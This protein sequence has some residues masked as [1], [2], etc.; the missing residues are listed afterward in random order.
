MLAAGE[1]RD[2]SFTLR[3]GGVIVSGTV[4]DIGGGPIANATVHLFGDNNAAFTAL[5]AA[6]GAYRLSIAPGNFSVQVRH[7]AYAG[8][9]RNVAVTGS[10][11]LDWQLVPAGTI[12]GVVIAR[13]T[14]RPVPHASVTTGAPFAEAVLAGDD[15]TFTLTGCPPGTVRLSANAPG[16]VADSALALPVGVGEHVD[17]VTLYADRAFAI[18][19]RV[20]D[21]K[22]AAV[23][24]AV[25]A[26]DGGA[27]V[28]TGADGAFELDR[29]PRSPPYAL[30]ATSPD[31]VPS[32][33]VNVAVVDRDVTGVAIDVARGVAVRGRVEPG[34]AAALELFATALAD[35][36]GSLLFDASSDDAGA[37]AFE[38]LGPG[39]YKLTARTPTGE[40]GVL[41]LDVAGTDVNGLVVTLDRR[42]VIHGHLV[43]D[44]GAPVGDRDIGAHGDHIAL[45]ASTGADGTF[46][47]TGLAAGTYHVFVEDE[48]RYRP[49][50]A[51]EANA[52]I[53]VAAAGDAS[54]TLTVPARD[55]AIR[56]NVV[57]AGGQPVPSALVTA[58]P[59]G[60]SA[61]FS[62]VTDDTGAFELRHLPR[63]ART[64]VNALGPHGAGASAL[65]DIGDTI[66][67]QLAPPCSLRGRATT[68]DGGPLG[69]Y[70][71]VCLGPDVLSVSRPAGDG[72]FELPYMPPGD[73]NCRVSASSGAAVAT[74]TI[75]GPT[76]HDFA[77]AAAGDVTG[78]LISATN[79]TPIANAYVD[80]HNVDDVN[81]GIVWTDA[82]GRFRVSHVMPGDGIVQLRGE[83]IQSFQLAPGQH[84]DLGAIEVR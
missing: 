8:T 10:I 56:G 73:Y 32:P 22:G 39:S 62:A 33:Y 79:G 72:T 57:D 1:T 36:D 17:A 5:T 34:A 24:G 55:G 46:A 83:T 28:T 37:F 51:P 82:T 54:V 43:D 84:L 45:S 35:R 3:A 19:G 12:R 25:V 15:G 52:T 2:I 44:S 70:T 75:A 30:H 71:L 78:T 69:P 4:G 27:P 65:G 18:R 66:T 59:I 13:D 47:F 64:I 58:S 7:D 23:A 31:A 80:A 67:L 38:H 68:S 40:S 11:R 76:T 20:V 74:M 53:A 14:G 16:Y 6:D 49:D 50:P 61:Q 42:A 48:Q 60:M 63:G 29:L 9:G 41:K 81:V 77:V 26:D 21:D